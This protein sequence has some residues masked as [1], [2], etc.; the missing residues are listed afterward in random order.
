M[1][2]LGFWGTSWRSLGRE[3][4]Q[5]NP[6]QK[7]RHEQSLLVGGSMVDLGTQKARMTDPADQGCAADTRE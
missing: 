3:R 6:K 2:E 7:E 1:A 5:E 4:R